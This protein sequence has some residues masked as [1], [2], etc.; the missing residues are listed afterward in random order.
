MSENLHQETGGKQQAANAC[1]GIFFL[2]DVSKLVFITADLGFDVKMLVFKIRNYEYVAYFWENYSK[3]RLIEH[4]K[5][6]FWN[7]VKNWFWNET[8]SMKNTL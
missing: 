4:F 8:F 3:Q 1:V 6:F 2:Y 5:Y 7:F